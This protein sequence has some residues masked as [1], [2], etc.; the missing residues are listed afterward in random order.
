MIYYYYYYN[1]IKMINVSNNVILLRTTLKYSSITLKYNSI[2]TIKTIILIT[3]SKIKNK[4]RISLNSVDKSVWEEFKNMTK[5]KYNKLHTVLSQEVEKAL[6]LYMKHNTNNIEQTQKISKKEQ[7]Y[8]K[9]AKEL[10]K[11]NTISYKTLKKIVLKTGV[12]DNRVIKSY[13]DNFIAIEWITEITE[14][15]KYLKIYKIDHSMIDIAFVKYEE[16]YNISFDF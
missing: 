16:K 14:T 2:N 8:I 9:I 15:P 6:L 13:I 5:L 7:N 4:T 12:S 3:M 10:V 11:Y 1:I